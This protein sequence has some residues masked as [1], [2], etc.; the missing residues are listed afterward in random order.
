[1]DCSHEELENLLCSTYND[2]LRDTPLDHMSG[3]P[4]PTR[5]GILFQLGELTLIEMKSFIQKS[6]AKSSHGQDGVPYKVYKRC[7]KLVHWLFLILKKAWNEK[8]I[9]QRWAKTEGIY[10]PKEA[11]AS[12]LSQFRLIALGNT[13]GKIF[14]GILAKRVRNFPSGI[15]SFTV[16]ESMY[17]R[18]PGLHQACSYDMG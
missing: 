14:F 15:D 9:I 7:P 8:F 13:D 5:P 18:L 10:I 1:M 6:R 16:T 12:S 2:P 3:I 17:S 11:G 4:R